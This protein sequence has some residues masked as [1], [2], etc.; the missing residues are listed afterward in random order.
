MS[1]TADQKEDLVGATYE[2]FEQKSPLGCTKENCFGCAAHKKGCTTQVRA[3]N[4]V[5]TEREDD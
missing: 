4:A 1:L 2:G 5:L 3:V